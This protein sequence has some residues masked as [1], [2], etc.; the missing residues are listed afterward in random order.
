MSIRIATRGSDL[1]LYQANYVA[2]RIEAELGA[3][4]ELVVI[5]TTGDRIQNV[6]LAKIGGKGLFVK[7]IEEALLDDRADVAVHS[8][9]DLPARLADDLA[10]VAFPQR[11]DFRDALVGRSRGASVEALPAGARVGTGSARRG[12]QLLAARPDLEIVALRGN[13]PTRLRKLESDD[14]AAV[15]LA[16]AG[17]DRLGFGDR[18]D[19]RI[20]PETILPAIAQGAIALEARRDD[21]IGREIAKLDDRDT[22]IC[23]AAE[24]GFLQGIGGDCTVPLA[25]LAKI[26]ET[27]KL[28]VRA[29]LASTDGSK[30]LRDEFEGDLGA[31][32][33]EAALGIAAAV[34]T[35]LSENV[36]AEGGRE[37]LEQLRSEADA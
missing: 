27:R 24:R 9:K 28:H 26:S 36:L 8:A 13:V 31:G 3:E 34:G 19:E 17:L 7:E 14:L 33:E 35:R 15:V 30:I 21:P 16:C 11:A 1:A 2:G 23:V 5:K 22:A 6:S 12:S 4:T 37:L 18:I 29:L 25:C 32:D 10:L 20:A